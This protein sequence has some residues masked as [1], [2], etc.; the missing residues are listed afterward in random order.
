[1]DKREDIINKVKAYATLVKNSGF[2]MP[3]EKTYLFGSF[4]KGSPHADSDID[5][6][7]VV[8]HWVGD[9]FQV[10][11]PIWRLREKIDWRI[12]PHV[13]VPEEDY[14]GLLHEIQKNGVEVS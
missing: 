9:F 12:E 2:P 5:V 7:F 1:M 3:I 10:I 8:R 6:A 11:P 14:G 13:V 4:A